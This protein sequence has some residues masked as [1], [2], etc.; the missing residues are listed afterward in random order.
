[1]GNQGLPQEQP[2]QADAGDRVLLL[3]Q[4][5]RG[6]QGLLPGPSADQVQGAPHIPTSTYPAWVPCM[7]WCADLEFRVARQER[8][9]LRS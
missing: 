8:L 9:L 2:G 1:M 3:P 6:G 5:A 7:S 4:P